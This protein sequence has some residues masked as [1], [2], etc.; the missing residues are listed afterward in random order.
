[1]FFNT[2][3]YTNFHE[4]NLDW[5]IATVK[6]MDGIVHNFVA[7]NKITFAGTW[8]GSPY[9][10]CTVVD[11]GLGNGYLA[12]K[13]VPANVPLSDTTYWT[14][15][16]SYASIYSAFNSRITAL[17]SAVS[18]LPTT[19]V[20]QTRTVNGNAL[21]SNVNVNSGQIPYDNTISGLSATNVKSALDEI[22]GHMDV[23]RNFTSTSWIENGI[24]YKVCKSGHICELL[25]ESGTISTA[26]S[27]NATIA[28]LPAGYEPRYIAPQAVD[29]VRGARIGIGASGVITTASALDAGDYVRFYVSYIGQ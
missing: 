26:F 14:Q 18:A 8:D 12:I 5:I 27:A 1:M 24:T 17:E 10:A 22:D 9:P 2:Y 19:Y 4:L 29:I 25:A 28:N 3:P 7:Y 23:L 20:P 11:D 13:A 21:S 16:A 15:V 6:Q